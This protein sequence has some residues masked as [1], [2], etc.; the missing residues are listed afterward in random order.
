MKLLAGATV[1]RDAGVAIQPG[2]TDGTNDLALGCLTLQRL[3][4]RTVHFGT[5][6]TRNAVDGMGYREEVPFAMDASFNTF[7]SV[8]IS[9]T[10]VIAS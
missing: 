3:I 8:T 2:A 4:V 10:I 7:K 1:R 6:E 9:K 5:G